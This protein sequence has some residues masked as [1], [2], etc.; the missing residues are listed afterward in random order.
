MRRDARPRRLR[1][2]VLSATSLVLLHTKRSL[3]RFLSYK[4]AVLSL[5]RRFF[6]SMFP[7]ISIELFV[8]AS[9]GRTTTCVGRT[10]SCVSLLHSIFLSF[11]LSL[12]FSLI[13]SLLLSL[14]YS[15]HSL[16]IHL[17]LF[18]LLLAYAKSLF[19]FSLLSPQ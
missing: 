3:K 1:C 12:S 7:S 5:S 11:S 6:N 10:R 16:S 13:P 17:S 19:N 4:H 14:T 18:S 9:R 2:V 15:S 8:F